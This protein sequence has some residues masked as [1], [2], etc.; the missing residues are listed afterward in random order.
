MH[1]N[2]VILKLK[3]PRNRPRREKQPDFK[4]AENIAEFL[5]VTVSVSV[6]QNDNNNKRAAMMVP[7]NKQF[8]NLRPSLEFQ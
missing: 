4:V 7:T 1:N 5:I 6:C 3:K 2:V 8:G